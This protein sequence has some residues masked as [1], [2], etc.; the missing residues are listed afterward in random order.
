MPNPPEPHLSVGDQARQFALD[1]HL[2]TRAR[3]GAQAWRTLGRQLQAALI[4]QRMLDR[5]HML[6]IQTHSDAQVR[7]VLA[8][9]NSYVDDYTRGE[10]DDA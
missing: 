6:G 4:A 7:E 10:V 8:V 3:L 2:D 1:A 5:L 9:C